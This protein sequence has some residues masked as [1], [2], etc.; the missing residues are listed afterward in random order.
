MYFYH[1]HHL[2]CLRIEFF[3]NSF[4]SPIYHHQM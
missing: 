3:Y 2:L 4:L 1:I